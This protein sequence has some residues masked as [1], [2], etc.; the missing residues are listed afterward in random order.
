MIYTNAGGRFLGVPMVVACSYVTI[1][2]NVF[3]I[4]LRILYR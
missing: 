4:F 3:T 1:A 2:I